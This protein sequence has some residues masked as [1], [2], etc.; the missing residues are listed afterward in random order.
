MVAVGEDRS[1]EHR[2]LRSGALGAA[3]IVFV[4][5]AGAAPLT[6]MAGNVPL[7]MSIG[8]GVGLPGAYVLVGIVLL[9][10]SVG[11]APAGSPLTSPPW[12]TTRALRR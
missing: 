9:L 10:F 2:T 1:A 5:V 11:F 4:V 7:G 6:A 3:G 12:A 8:N